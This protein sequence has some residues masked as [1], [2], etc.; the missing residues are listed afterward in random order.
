MI[1]E[2][3]LTWIL[4]SLNLFELTQIHNSNYIKEILVF[5]ITSSLLITLCIFIKTKDTYQEMQ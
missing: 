2:N 3:K 5:G 4:K 1:C